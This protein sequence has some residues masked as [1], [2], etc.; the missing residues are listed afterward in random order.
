[1]IGIDVSFLCFVLIVMVLV[2]LITNFLIR[3]REMMKVTKTG[4][5]HIKENNH[6]ESF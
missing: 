4:N 2:F 5:K 6:K 3:K 1:M